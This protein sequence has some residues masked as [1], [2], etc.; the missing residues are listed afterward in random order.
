MTVAGNLAFQ[1]GALYLVTLN[2]TASTFANVTGTATL[3]GTVGA[4]FVPGS[5]VMKQYMILS[6]SGGVS[7]GFAGVG[8]ASPS[9]GLVAT[10]SYDPTHAYL[11]FA[12]DFGVIPGLNV[13]QRNVG[14]ALTNFF[15]ANGG[16]PVS[17]ATLTPG[18]LTQAS[19]ELATGS[20][21]ATFDAMN[22]FMGLLTDPFVAGRGGSPPPGPSAPIGY[23]ST[24]D[25]GAARDAYAMFTK[26]PLAQTYDPRWSVWAA[27]Y[28]G[29]QTTDG[30]TA[31]GSNTATSSVYGT[32][33]GADY[34]I[35][36][37]HRCG[38]CARWRRH[39][40]LGRG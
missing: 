39:K 26:A 19:G 24:Q 10:L 34:R 25:I 32:A 29:S 17:F 27:G 6:A 5:E 28:G 22:L 8:L 36:A 38:F 11:N 31:L 30:N 2:S 4:A 14:T 9:G 18:G 21:Q 12:L 1:S 33:V 13:N 3:A 23:A 15:N 37:S 16:I 35:L 40:L 20:Q 7:G